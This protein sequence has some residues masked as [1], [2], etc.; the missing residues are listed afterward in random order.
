MLP[1]ES[2][3]PH[4]CNVMVMNG[5]VTDVRR[6]GRSAAA[7]FSGGQSAGLLETCESLKR[8]SQVQPGNSSAM[9]STAGF[10]SRTSPT[11]VP[12]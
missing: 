8:R 11:E 10:T 6:V 4:A 9:I 12:A 5:D 1:R 2:R 3:E 7:N